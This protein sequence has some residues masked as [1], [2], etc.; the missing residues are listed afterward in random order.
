MDLRDLV[1]ALLSFNALAARQ[2]VADSLREG[3]VW[4]SA[5]V[6]LGL[7]PIGLG[8]AAGVAKLLAERAGQVPPSWV[9]SVDVAPTPVYLMKTALT[10]PRLRRLFEQEGPEPLRRRGILASPEFLEVA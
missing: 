1:N 9:S 3:F 7:D 8:M 2:W 10:M 5:P 4:A 6:S